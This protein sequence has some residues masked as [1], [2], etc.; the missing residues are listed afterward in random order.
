MPAPEPSI[1]YLA[2]DIILKEGYQAFNRSPEAVL[3][4][5]GWTA[6]VVFIARELTLPQG[7]LSDPWDD[8]NRGMLGKLF[9]NSP[10]N[11]VLFDKIVEP[12]L[13]NGGITG[14][15]SGSRALAAASDYAAKLLGLV[16]ELHAMGFDAS[17]RTLSNEC[18]RDYERALVMWVEWHVISTCAVEKRELF[19]EYA[20]RAGIPSLYNKEVLGDRWGKRFR[21]NYCFMVEE[22]TGCPVTTNEVLLLWNEWSARMTP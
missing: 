21:E 5:E 12:I 15:W 6:A 11:R 1:H 3:E 7:V 22:I 4:D 16:H 10:Q 19:T 8:E 18:R 17:P 13:H 2:C 20:L 9:A 14:V